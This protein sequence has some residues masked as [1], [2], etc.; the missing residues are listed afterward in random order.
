MVAPTVEVAATSTPVTP[1]A[2]PVIP[3]P[4]L[5]STNTVWSAGNV[6]LVSGT[7]TID[8]GVSLSIQAGA[9]VKF[10]AYNYPGKLVANGTILAQGTAQ[11]RVIFTSVYDDSFGGDTN[12][13]G[14]GTW[15]N[16]GDWVGLQLNST[17]SGSLLENV[18]IG[19]GGSD[20]TEPRGNLVVNGGSATLRNS[21]IG[22]SASNGVTWAGGAGGQMNTN[23]VERSALSGV[24]LTGAS[25]PVVSNNIL[26]RNGSYAISIS[27]N[28]PANFQANTAYSN[29]YN[30]I[31]VSGTLVSSTWYSNLPY[32]ITDNLTLETGYTLSIRSGATIKFLPGKS[33]ILRGVLNANAGTGAPIIFT[34]LLDDSFGGDTNGDGPATKPAP[35]DWGT[36]LFSDTSSGSILN[37]AII[38]YGGAAYYFSS[39]TATANITIN[40]TSPTISN[41]HIQF[42]KAYGFQLTDVSSPSLTG[43]QIEDNLSHGAWLSDSSSPMVTNNHFTRNSGYAVYQAGASQA[44]YSNNFM[45]GNKT[46]AIGV[47]GNL[48]INATWGPGVPH[49]I[50]GNVTLG[51]DILLTLQPGTIVKFEPNAVLAVNGTLAAQGEQG[52]PVLFTS[53]KDDTAGGDTNNDAQTTSPAAGDWVAINFGAS[54]STSGLTYVEVRYGGSSNYNSGALVF[55]GGAPGVLNQV[56]VRGSRYRGV[57]CQNSAPN[58]QGGSFSENDTAFYAYTGCSLSVHQANL[59]RNTSYGINNSGGTVDVS[60]NWW[61]AA[62]GPTVNSNPTGTGDKIYGTVTYQ[63]F[64]AVIIG[65]LPPLLPSPYIAPMYSTVSGAI[66][67][68]TTWMVASSPYLVT[69]D[70]TVNLGVRLTIQPGV[71]VKFGDGR[72]LTI[73]GILNAVGTAANPIIFTSS[74]DDSAGGDTNNDGTATQPAPG[75]WGSL[76]FGNSSNDTQTFLSYAIVRYGGGGSYSMVRTDSASPTITHN[77]ITF[78]ANYGVQFSNYS[79]PPFDS[80]Q[81]LDN[82]KGGI[83]LESGSY[84]AIQDNTIWGNSGFAV[85]MDGSCKPTFENNTAYYNTNNT[86]RVAGTIATDATWNANLVY[87]VEA[88]LTIDTGATL[89]INPGAVV[90][91]IAGIT[92]NGTIIADGAAD[93]EIIFTSTHDDRFGGDTNNN[94]GSTWP[95][96]ANWGSITF[97]DSSDDTLNLLNHTRLLYGSD[98]LVITSSAP[99]I[100][101]STIAYA[102]NYGVNLTVAA[103]PILEGNRIEHNGYAGLGM[104]G[105]SFPTLTANVFTNNRGRALYMS[106]DCKPSITGN[107]I[108]DNLENAIYVSGWVSNT[109]WSNNIP[110]SGSAIVGAGA[111][112]TLEPGVVIKMSSFSISGVLIA[113]ALDNQPVVFTSLQ[114]DTAGGDT[115]NDGISTTPASGDWTTITIQSGGQAILNHVVVRFGGGAH[116][117]SGLYNSGGSLTITNSTISNNGFYGIE[118]IGNG[119]LSV[120]GS[121]IS[122]HASYGIYASSGSSS[123]PVTPIVQDNIFKNNKLPLYIEYYSGNG[124]ISGNT[125][126]G[127][128]TNGIQLIKIGGNTTLAAN[129]NLPY[130]GDGGYY[131]TIDTGAVVNVQP[132]VVFK[133]KR[134]ISVNGNLNA[135]GQVGNPIIFTSL[136]DDTAGGDTN[137]DG[138]STTPASGDWENITTQSGGQAILNHV[139][140][141]FGGGLVNL[142]GGN[143]TINNSTISRNSF[144]VYNADNTNIINAENNYWGADN[145][146]APYGVG[147]GINYTQSC[148][149]GVC[150]IV[151]YVD[152]IPWVGQKSTFGQSIPWFV[153]V[154]EP[155]N[156]A[157]GNYTY[158]HIDL[159]MPTRSYPLEMVRAYNSEAPQ[160]GPLGYGWTH[161][162]NVK[163]LEN[164][165]GSVSIIY[166]D[167]RE[168]RYSWNGSS[169]TPPPGIFSRLEK[170]SGAYRVTFKDQ[171][172]YEFNTQGYLNRT[173]DRNGNST[174]LNYNGNLLA[175]ITAP[176]GRVFTFTYT[177]G[178]ITR[179]IDPLN[180]SATFTYDGNGDLIGAAT[181]A[182]GATAFTYDAN[183]R[184]L[185]IVDANNNTVVTNIYNTNGQV[186]QQQNALNQLTTFAYDIPNHKTTV[187]DH[188]N[189]TTVYQYDAMLR[190][191]S[192]TDGLSHSETYTYDAANNRTSLKDRNGNTTTYTYDDH[193]N[194]LTITTPL[195][196][197]TSYTYD[198]FNNPLTATDA[199]GHITTFT[200]DGHGNRLSQVDPLNRTTIFSYFVDA[201]R[202]GKLAALTDP[203]GFTTT[204]NY[205]AQGDLMSTVDGVGST[206]SYTYDLGGRKLTYVD[207]RG[208][209]WSYT[210]DEANRILSEIDPLGNAITY[211]YDL[212]GNLLTVTDR[213]GRTTTRTYDALNRLKT[214]IDTGGYTT[215]Y[216]YDAA[217]NLTSVTDGNNHLT[218]FTYDAANRLIR[219]TNPL[220]QQINYTLDNNGNRTQ[221]KDALN[222]ITATAYDTLN[223][224]IRQTNALGQY[225][226]T[227]YDAVG[228]VV[229][230][231]D[232][233]GHSTVYTYDNANQLIQTTDPLSNSVS[234]NYDLS[235]NR[236]SLTDAL[237][238]TTT[239]TYD[240]MNRQISVTDPLNHITTST[241]DKNGNKLTRTD[242]NGNVTTYDYNNLNWLMQITYAV[243]GTIVKYSYDATG[244]RLTMTDTLGVTSYTY[245]GLD[246]PLSIVSPNGTLNY[247][248]NAKN[249]LTL[250]TPAGTTTYIY[251][252]ADRL[253]N[254]VDWA[255]RTTT[256]TYDAAGR[257]TNGVLPNGTNIAYGYDNADRLNS[258]IAKK[259]ATT[260]GS[261]TYVLDA[262]GNRLTMVDF[263]GTTAYTYDALDRLTSI[264]YPS[265]MPSVV[266]YTYDAAGNRLS[267]TSAGNNT[268]YTYD[269]A[270]RLITTSIGGSTTNY[271]WDANGNLL[272]RGSEAF[273]WDEAKRLVGWT[274]GANSASYAYDGDGVRLNRTY[275]GTVT[276][277]LQDLAA[278]LP[279]VLR[280]T[281]NSVFSDYVYGKDLILSAGVAVNYYYSDALGSTRLLADGSGTISDRYTYDAFG[282]IRSHTGASPTSFTFAGEQADPEAGLIYLRARYYDPIIGRFISPDAWKGKASQPQTLNRYVYVTN[283]P[284]NQIDPTGAMLEDLKEKWSNLTY[285]VQH[286]QEYFDGMK[287]ALADPIARGFVLDEVAENADIVSTGSELVGF[288]PGAVFFKG[289]KY[290]AKAYNL[291]DTYQGLK[292]GVVP[293]SVAGERAIKTISGFL[294]DKVTDKLGNEIASRVGEMSWRLGT[295]VGG[296]FFGGTLGEMISHSGKFAKFGLDEILDQLQVTDKFSRS[297]Y[298]FLSSIGYR[299]Y[300]PGHPGSIGGLSGSG[301]FYIVVNPNSGGGAK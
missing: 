280:E 74:R 130:V 8:A 66:T 128:T 255:N 252:A 147:N 113:D 126:S 217:G 224:P 16:P 157:T 277:Y 121:E 150:V 289:V 73:N 71:V 10:S 237:G 231:V 34:S 60:N 29:H 15:P 176:D 223:R 106:G 201:I 146:P 163:V 27:G 17:A 143:L 35:G 61:N 273:S 233:L 69:G 48:N 278:S 5:I 254:V 202:S 124:T 194:V 6:Y 180:R 139:D 77:L 243:D 218:T 67:K 45:E 33:L 102:S 287:M 185:T 240:G 212:V 117:W 13:D 96:P 39:A 50:I 191:I 152:V 220:T 246:R 195:D 122:N 70:V 282:A 79:A 263:N 196:E 283:N 52:N 158:S 58:F 118:D 116:P 300:A 84:P 301:Y 57:Y 188:L 85:Y 93:S 123:I 178:R 216:I 198:S 43:N 133:I 99:R 141:R 44:V 149:A 298:N 235:G 19:Y 205:N 62:N 81:V 41:T 204:Y 261:F 276:A 132:G 270:N 107:T 63:P 120:T 215:A 210:Y 266:S 91:L 288:K 229:R 140:V 151:P 245:D 293:E 251:D 127:N 64:S 192:Q 256:Y 131:L 274:N 259:G 142:V 86:I 281:T 12:H 285:N 148:I 238:H 83:L 213:L 171:A 272:T 9:I 294:L 65:S 166:G 101:Y 187:T 135:Q 234:M 193:G 4:A 76:A 156:T 137:N 59:Y 262:N 173:L 239:Y 105:G 297:S 72:S 100:A 21:Y 170:A 98:L 1:N 88:N 36:L 112:L 54:A 296:T 40:N 94:G 68:D 250:V 247:T 268:A 184:L 103:N 159:S 24:S 75:N 249:R 104:S 232:A 144:G 209:T 47:S 200:Y 236:V 167:G 222:H 207:G 82:L 221:V 228:N 241:Y 78:S 160:D 169:Y 290:A 225:T 206:S 279:V 109:T 183:H 23:Y 168:E 291:Y 208:K 31:G 38:R 197:M 214:Q 90:K 190:L 211:T 26:A 25:K 174:I 92:V 275:N 162:Y 3:V 179:V 80:N 42:S 258:V 49:V 177:G 95:K 2:M 22:Y 189:H 269:V 182:D 227:F 32:L 53:L 97:N 7:T 154:A 186:I 119:S 295:R 292:A 181:P 230:L 172:V 51:T 203:R 257:L 284:I 37:N 30:G 56:T 248:Y 226:Q 164:G 138:T 129:S 20:Y 136:Q 267:M 14:G 244:N 28:S 219:A 153:F 125:G 46:N 286:P 299:N 260:L 165:D 110:Y 175:S 89:T 114:D 242:A 11:N 199:L 55:N 18:W 155:V 134:V 253:L 145:G 161:S 111:T 115:N 87:Y 108:T 271:S 264:T 265:G